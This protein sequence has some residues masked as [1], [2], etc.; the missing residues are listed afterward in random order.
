M[1]K[2]IEGKTIQVTLR[3]HGQEIVTPLHLK[4]LPSNDYCVV[5]QTL[6]G[7]SEGAMT[8]GTFKDQAAFETW[9][10]GKMGDGTNAP[11]NQVY[12][13]VAKGVSDAEAEDLIASPRNT[14]AVELS[15]MRKLRTLSGDLIL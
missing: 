15:L 8:R 10:A 5:L 2:T 12:A 14:N 9:Y 4:P 11:L 13:V 1:G 6:V 7:L 3:G